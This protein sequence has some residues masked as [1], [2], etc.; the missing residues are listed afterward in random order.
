MPSATPAIVLSAVGGGINRLRTKGAVSPSTLYDLLNGYVTAAGTVKVRPGTTRNADLSATAGA[1]T[2]K[3]LVGYQGLLHTFSS[4]VVS[5]PA[6]YALHVLGHPV[7]TVL[8]GVPGATLTSTC[9]PGANSTPIIG[10]PGP[11]VGTSAAVVASNAASSFN[12]GVKPGVYGGGLDITGYGT[13]VAAGYTDASNMFPGYTVPVT[14]GIFCVVYTGTQP[15]NLFQSAQFERG[16][17]HIIDSYSTTDPNLVYDTTTYPG[18]T[19][20]AWPSNI[21]PFTFTGVSLVVS[22]VGPLTG[23]YL[24]VPIKEIHFAAPFLGGLY[25]VAEF[26]PVD[27]TQSSVGS[28][29]HYWIQSSTGSDNANT[30]QA[31]NDYGIGDVVIPST[32]NGLTFVASR[33][34]APNPTW[35]AGVLHSVNDI[36]EPT[37][38][39][40]FK[41]TVISVE[42]T[43]P[44]TGT[45]EPTWPTTSGLTI[46]ENSTQSTDQTF[47]PATAAS[48]T[49]TPSVP[50]RYRNLLGGGNG[51]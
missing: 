29:F 41:Y 9:T 24:P 17:P 6:G 15:Q 3:G 28:V 34:S 40:S 38:Y 27:S 35:Q 23:Q 49:P 18:Y 8:T 13:F 37:V 1:G 26:Q 51:V 19:V 20:F 48:S 32:P 43:N 39:N 14:N 31:S 46:T 4:S 47:T 2:T 42:G 45:D 7:G 36:I 16:S 22:I 11:N 33:H 21:S 12:N 44:S 50:P 25:V 30:W 10:T 5:V